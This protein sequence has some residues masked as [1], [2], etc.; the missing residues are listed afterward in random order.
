MLSFTPHWGSEGG[1]S[2]AALSNLTS[3]LKWCSPLLDT[4]YFA[5]GPDMHHLLFWEAGK[6]L[7]VRYDQVDKFSKSFMNNGESC[8]SE[9]DFRWHLNKVTIWNFE[10]NAEGRWKWVAFLGIQSIS[11]EDLAEWLDSNFGLWKTLLLQRY[12]FSFYVTSFFRFC[13]FQLQNRVPQMSKNVIGFSCCFN[14]KVSPNKET[15]HYFIYLLKI[16]SSIQ[17][18]YI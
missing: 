11:G 6:H 9:K 4:S 7:L 13:D 5:V 14:N 2:T 3:M 17:N 12:H 10:A 1:G 18:T 15:K 8:I 16:T